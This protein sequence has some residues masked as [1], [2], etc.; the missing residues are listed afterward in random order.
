VFK[1]PPGDF[2]GRLV[3]AAGLKGL[4][5]GDAQIAPEHGNFI[6]NCGRARA[7][8]IAALIRAAREKV[9]EKFQVALELE[10]RVLGNDLEV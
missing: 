2:A 6:V 5:I 7:R 4:R 1:N 10:I 8:D 9:L 3:E